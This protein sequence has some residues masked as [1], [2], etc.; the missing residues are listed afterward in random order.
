MS[1]QYKKWKPT[2]LWFT[3]LSGSG[4]STIS[5]KVFEIING[6]GYEV[7]HLDGDVIRDIFPKTGFT[8]A[9]RNA[10]IKRVGYIASRMQ[11]HNIFVIGSF[12]SPYKEGRDF[13]R[14]LCNDFTEVYISTPYEECER[15]DVKGL[16]AKAKAGEI[17]H[18]T[19]LEDPFEAPENP[20]LT[21]DTT[22]I[23]LDDA[24]SIVINYLNE[25]KS[26][27]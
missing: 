13:V 22:N 27:D 21:I 10:H 11:A 14:N 8:E 2:V 25:H 7:E 17:K 12:V 16:Y 26:I 23:S 5:E 15:R 9:E 6:L 4:K 1:Q 18:F 24:V 3:G 19:G 20:E